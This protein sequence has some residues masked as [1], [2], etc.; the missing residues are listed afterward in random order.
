M[1]A[2][3]DFDRETAVVELGDGVYRA[4]LSPA[5]SVHRGPNGGYL[6]AVALR[7]L[8]EAVGDAERSPRSLTIHYAAPP[9]APASLSLRPP[10]VLALVPAI[11]ANATPTIGGPAAAAGPGESVEQ[12]N[13]HSPMHAY[14]TERRLIDNLHSPGTGAVTGEV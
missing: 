4:D 11:G 13:A 9:A 1:G 5:W 7:A 3:F 6:A 10:P 8:T 14:T 12:P 2:E